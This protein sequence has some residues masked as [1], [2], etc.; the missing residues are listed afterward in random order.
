MKTKN[1][2][3]G[4]IGSFVI[5]SGVASVARAQVGEAEVVAEVSVPTSVQTLDDLKLVQGQIQRVVEKVRPATVALTSTKSGASGSGVIVN[6]GGLILTAA[7]VVQGNDEMSVI[8]PN[9]KAHTAKV[10]GSNRT[11]DVAMLQLVKKQVWPYAEI[12]ES[13]TLEVGNHVIAMG[14][15]GGYDTRRPAP[16]RFGRLLSKNRK[17]FITS[18]SVLIGG[19]SGGPLFDMNGKVVG[20]NSSIG[21]SRLTNNHAGISALVEDWDRLLKGDTWGQLNQNPLADPDS[22]VM[23]FT[24]EETRANNGV[25]VMEVLDDSPADR[26]GFENGD[27]LTAIENEEVKNGRDLLVALNHHKPDDTIEVTLIRVGKEVKLRIKLSRRGEFF[28]R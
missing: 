1:L 2:W 19:D 3:A 28:K 14:H 4:V 16:V 24:F 13:D 18:D 9:G 17:G 5:G 10:L 15:A 27:V 20:I 25:I 7:H 11:K 22:P 8:F 12:G 23:G 26:A 21:Q 6:Q